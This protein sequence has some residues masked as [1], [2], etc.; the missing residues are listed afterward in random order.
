MAGA[1]AG[2]QENVLLMKALLLTLFLPLVAGCQHL[3]VL[4]ARKQEAA[5]GRMYRLAEPAAPVEFTV[6]R[7][8]MNEAVVRVPFDHV[9]VQRRGPSL[10]LEEIA[11]TFRTNR[12]GMTMLVVVPATNVMQAVDRPL[13]KR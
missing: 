13:P 4:E 6:T 8:A 7:A 11:D 9:V 2:G 5:F 10:T 12:A 3:S 1:V